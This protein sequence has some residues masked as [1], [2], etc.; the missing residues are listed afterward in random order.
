MGCGVGS[1]SRAGRSRRGVLADRRSVANTTFPPQP[2][3]KLDDWT[4]RFY[5][6]SGNCV[7]RDTLAGVPRAVQWQHG[8]A[9]EDGTADGKVPRVA[10]GRFVAFD[11]L[12]GELVCRD[13]SNGSLLWRRFIGSPQNAD[14]AIVGGQIYL[15]HDPQAEPIA[16]RRYV[17]SGPLVAIDLATGEL[18]KTYDEAL[19]AG[20]AVGRRDGAPRGRSAIREIQPGAVVHRARRCD[21]AEDRLEKPKQECLFMNIPMLAFQ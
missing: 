19:R 4:H 15:Y 21:R 16:D 3:E 7:S 14:L 9:L 11:G 20:T 10:D 13:A 8:P 17:E 18:T 1:R 5:D 2:P 12:S 6:A